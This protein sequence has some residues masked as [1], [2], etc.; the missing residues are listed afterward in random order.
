MYEFISF[1]LTFNIIT[2][3]CYLYSLTFILLLNIYLQYKITFNSNNTL[4]KVSN[5]FIN[6][7]K[8]HI[9][10]QHFLTNKRRNIL[11]AT[12]PFFIRVK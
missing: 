10:P 11:E 5:N 6:M 1:I 7:V 12:A 4:T 3:Y 2:T 9:G 8:Q